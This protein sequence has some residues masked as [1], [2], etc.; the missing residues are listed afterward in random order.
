MKIAEIIHSLVQLAPQTG[1]IQIIFQ[2][3][4]G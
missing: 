4:K 1:T 2:N 3:P